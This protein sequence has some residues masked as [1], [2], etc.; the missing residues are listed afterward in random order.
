MSNSDAW[1]YGIPIMLA[2]WGGLAWLFY[3]K[4]GNTILRVC[5]L[6]F[7]LAC[8]LGALYLHWEPYMALICLPAGF[9]GGLLFAEWYY[10]IHGIIAL[11]SDLLRQRQ[12]L[13]REDRFQQA[14][15]PWI[16]SERDALTYQ[17]GP[18]AKPH[19]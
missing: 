7:V 16:D 12:L 19:A 2:F 6:L 15:R 8:L 5:G 9:V 1:A 18:A 10:D 17:S 14:Q 11:R 3:S 13:E 4:R